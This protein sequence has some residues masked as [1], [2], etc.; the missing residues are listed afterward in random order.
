MYLSSIRK[1]TSL[2]KL[3]LL[4]RVINLQSFFQLFFH[5]PD[6]NT[7]ICRTSPKSTINS[8][9][10]LIY[11]HKIDT[12]FIKHF[13]K[14]NIYFMSKL[15][16]NVATVTALLIG[17]GFI[18]YIEKRVIDLPE[19]NS[20]HPTVFILKLIYIIRKIFQNSLCQR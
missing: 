4:Y 2:S 11:Q 20:S 13:F 10:N 17:Y 15:L 9:C 1:S 14:P 16:V 7:N 5:Y 18:F 12:G 8:T 3:Q 6:F 19:N